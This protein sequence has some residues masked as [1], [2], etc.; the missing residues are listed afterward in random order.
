MT[1]FYHTL[2]YLQNQY[3]NNFEL[4][5]LSFHYFYHLKYLKS[6]LNDMM[7]NSFTVMLIF[8][9]SKGWT[10]TIPENKTDQNQYHDHDHKI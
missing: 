10:T 1:T 3:N 2:V 8:N 7:E 4:Y 9:P 5:F 6:S